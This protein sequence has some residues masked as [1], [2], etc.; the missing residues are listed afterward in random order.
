MKIELDFNVRKCNMKFRSRNESIFI[1]GKLLK[2]ERDRKCI[3][4]FI[5]KYQI[6]NLIFVNWQTRFDLVLSPK[7]IIGFFKADS[8][9][10]C[11]TQIDARKGGSMLA[12]LHPEKLFCYVIIITQQ[13]LDV[14]C[15]KIAS[16][17]MRP[18]SRHYLS[19]SV[20][21]FLEISHLSNFAIKIF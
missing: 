6:W 5:A 21:S 18:C 11:F 13:R 4:I 14:K 20:T 10:I 16:G 1:V 17:H 7:S 9:C 15:I 8:S 3:Y 12:L 2:N 19:L